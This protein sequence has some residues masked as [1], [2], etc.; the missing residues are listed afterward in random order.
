M[1]GMIGNTEYASQRSINRYELFDPRLTPWY[2]EAVSGHKSVVILIDVSSADGLPAAKRAALKILDTLGPNDYVSLFTYSNS[3]SRLRDDCFDGTAMIRG[4]SANIA[5]LVDGV[6]SLSASDGGSGVA[7]ALEMAFDTLDTMST[8]CSPII[9][10]FSASSGGSGVSTARS[11]N[12]K[13]VV[14]S[15]LA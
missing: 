6:S 5:K 15:P 13:F 14:R 3:V 1:D 9:I 4:T 11:R 7:L 10:L 2:A 8:A 12:D